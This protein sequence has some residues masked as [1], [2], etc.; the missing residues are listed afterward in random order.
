MPRLHTLSLLLLLTVRATAADQD[1]FPARIDRAAQAGESG[2]ATKAAAPASD[3]EFLRRI[4]LDLTGMPPTSREA[5]A[6]LSDTT[7]DRRSRLIDRL[8]GSFHYT[9]QMRD[10]LDISLMERRPDK[11]VPRAAW[12][13]YLRTSVAAN[14]HWDVLVRELLTTDGADPKTRPASKFYLDREGE[15]NLITRD[16]G[17]LFLGLNLTCAQCHDHPLV[18][19]YRQEHYYGVFS[20]LNRSYL[21]SDKATKLTVFAEKAEGEATY[22]SVFDPKK[23][24]RPGVPGLPG[25]GRIKEPT[26]EK[27][28]EYTVAPAKDVRPIPRYSRR[29][30]LAEQVANK[31]NVA[32]RRNFA[33]RLWAQMTGRGLVHPLDLD[34]PANP[35]S[36][37]ELLT[38]L[39]DEGAAL[40]FDLRQFLRNIALSQTYQ[41]GSEW[42]AGVQD[43]PAKSLSVARLRPLSPEQLAWSLMQATG[44][45][46]A[47]RQALG[48]KATD[49]T[50]HA[51]LAGQVATFATVFGARP[52]H[53]DQ[54]E[55]RM[56]QALFL[57]NGS[58]VRGW[59]TPRSG[60]LMDRLAKLTKN[61][62]IAEELYLGILTRM[63]SREEKS[64]VARVLQTPGADRGAALQE[65]AWA[66]LASA[67]FRFNH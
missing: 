2:L 55:P 42:P 56:D 29:A 3:A 27:G 54:F 18:E 30:Q 19:S 23:E 36:H 59:L 10:N 53:A 16:V 41:R 33:N 22:Q 38:I 25:R 5:R 21:F 7:P 20:F 57:S 8:L 46:E 9:R 40:G 49:E 39:A 15:P 34:H 61:E 1:S 31:E 63:P 26:L 64:E 47:E 14:K 48:A 45:L 66:L 60:N 44:Q 12:Q 11:H 28:K 51:R 35:P 62:E 37:P 65:M 4:S 43:V 67:E 32:F 24:T 6:F 50:I 58:V 17:R 13:D 52:G